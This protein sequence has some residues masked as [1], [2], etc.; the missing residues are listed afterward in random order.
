MRI[1]PNAIRGKISRKR[2]K[3]PKGL[4]VKKLFSPFGVVKNLYIVFPELHSWLFV[5][6]PF[7]IERCNLE[8]Y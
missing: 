1:A 8:S 2:L 7:G 4:N 5:F 6:N 3:T